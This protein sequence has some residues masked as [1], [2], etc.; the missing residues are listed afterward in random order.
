MMSRVEEV[1][2]ER[3]EVGMRVMLR[4]AREGDDPVPVFVPEDEA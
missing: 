3:V 4:V 2:A 1:P